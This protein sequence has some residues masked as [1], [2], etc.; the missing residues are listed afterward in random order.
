MRNAKQTMLLVEEVPED[1]ELATQALRI[2]GH[3]DKIRVVRDG[4]DALDF[5]FA[6]GEYARRERGLQPSVVLLDI[7]LPRLSGFDVLARVHSDPRTYRTPIV[8]HTASQDDFDINRAYE[9][10]AS[11]YV[12]KHGDF[13][14]Y[15]GALKKIADYWLQVNVA[16]VSPRFLSAAASGQ[17]RMRRSS[18]L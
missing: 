11:S 3:A 18:A 5:L 9:L 15:C 6:E 7:K 1:I 13:A 4:L 2:C 17:V 12:L 16:P 10:G 8:I 14:N